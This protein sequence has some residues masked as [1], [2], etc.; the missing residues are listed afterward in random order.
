MVAESVVPQIE[1]GPFYV[2]QTIFVVSY[3]VL[4]VVILILKLKKLQIEQKKQIYTLFLAFIIPI[5]LNFTI[6]FVLLEVN[7]VQLFAPPSILVM[8]G[9]VTY[10]IVKQRLFDM[11]AIV[12]RS[13]TYLLF[14][15]L[16]ATGYVFIV[17]NFGRN[18]LTN[19]GLSEYINPFYIFAT[20]IVAVSFT[21]IVR[22]LTKL[23]DR[24][25][26]RD[27]YDPQEV[28]DMLSSHFSSTQRLGS[29]LGGAA[30]V[31]SR[32]LKPRFIVI[33]PIQ[34]E[35]E[36]RTHH[37]SLGTHSIDIGQLNALM[38]SE[39][40]NFINAE[41]INEHQRRALF[42]FLRA[43]NIS[44]VTRLETQQELVGY[45]VL[46]YKESGYLY[47]RNDIA[48]IRIA[49]EQLAIAMQNGLRF[50]EISAFNETLQAKV[51]DA[52]TKL[53]Q[54]NAKLKLIDETKDEFISMASHQLR[55]PLT[56]IKGYLSM[57]LDGDVGDI[58]QRQRKV[59]EE[60]FNSS[61]RMVYLI[62]DFLNVSRLQTGKFELERR[63]TNLA[64]VVGQEVRQM[65]DSAK[66]RNIKIHY[67]VPDNFP[68]TSIDENKIRQVIMNF[69]DNA[70]FYT[71]PKDTIQVSLLQQ[72]EEVILKVIDHGIGVPAGERHKLF[73]KFFRATN[74]KKQRPDGT[75][76]GLF[77]ARKVI[78][79]HGGS[80]IFETIEGKGSTF[81]FR[82][83]ITSPDAPTR[84]SAK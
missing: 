57:V 9:I 24:I 33:L 63:G 56:T 42:R 26:F 53:R 58:T 82:L 61:Q 75:G 14:I 76:I 70:I 80:I 46:G 43:H 71:K 31:L 3:F 81:G 68:M 23:T 59:L 64:D 62:G 83:P 79:A 28:I 74:A 49:S 35:K 6:N 66:S 34:S 16:I 12:V 65:Q 13:V 7:W 77:M 48:L 18:I 22:Q 10:A 11:R 36:N 20:L 44:I 67:E 25:F 5:V 84:R 1:T 4:G 21:P 73:S 29:M 30:D 69:I 19:L 54:S 47:Q 27:S 55:T 78:T 37:A 39:S 32:A 45:L 52:T 72:G 2:F 50:E 15:I 38:N 41:E 51:N 60:A 8:A 17:L 40:S